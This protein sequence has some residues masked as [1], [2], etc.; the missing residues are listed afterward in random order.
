[1]KKGTNEIVDENGEGAWWEVY[2]M[3]KKERKNIL[4]DITK[5]ITIFQGIIFLGGDV[6]DCGEFFLRTC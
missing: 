5:K 3:E 6:L 1:M 2:W 4:N